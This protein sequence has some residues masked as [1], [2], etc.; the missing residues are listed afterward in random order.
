MN[1]IANA[2]RAGRARAVC[3]LAV[4][5]VLT[6]PQTAHAAARIYGYAHAEK[7]LVSFLSDAP[8]DLVGD[9]ALSGL[10]ASEFLAGMDF[11]PANGVLYAV[12]IDG[13]LFRLVTIDTATGLVTQVGTPQSRPFG[14]PYGV[15]FDPVADSLSV[16]GGNDEVYGID[17]DTGVAVLVGALTY[18]TA[19]SPSIAHIAYAN[20]IA[21]A[22]TTVLYGIDWNLETSAVSGTWPPNAGFLETLGFLGRGMV[23]VGGFDIEPGTNAAYA[24]LQRDVTFSSLYSVDLATGAAAEIGS[25]GGGRLLGIAIAPEPGAFASALC[26]VALVRILRSGRNFPVRGKRA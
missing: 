4:G 14:S 15:D 20:S 23:A 11:R 5:C 10:G 24:A 19:D 12:A 26:A 17:P 8:G 7:R 16:V 3:A 21:G 9:V 1:A 25:I 22:T 6:T 2:L 13:D 18:G